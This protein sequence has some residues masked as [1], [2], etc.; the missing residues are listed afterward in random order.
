MADSALLFCS[1][2]HN[3]GKAINLTS[4]F[5][6]LGNRLLFSDCSYIINH[7]CEYVNNKPYDPQPRFNSRRLTFSSNQTGGWF[8]RKHRQKPPSPRSHFLLTTASQR[9]RF[10]PSFPPPTPIPLP[11]PLAHIRQSTL[12]RLFPSPSPAKPEPLHA[13]F[14]ANSP[15]PHPTTRHIPQK[16]RPSP[17]LYTLHNCSTSNIFKIIM[18]QVL[19]ICTSIWYNKY[20]KTH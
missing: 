19:D 3:A 11:D 8:T 9:T 13:P 2:L 7:T 6:T 15:I 17:T 18:S 4:F 1:C 5:G 20:S 16:T 12:V 14:C 10:P